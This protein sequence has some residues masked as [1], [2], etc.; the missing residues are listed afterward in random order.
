MITKITL[1]KHQ[2]EAVN[3]INNVLQDNNKCLVKM[4]CGTGKTRV[5]FYLMI[6]EY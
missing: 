6:V 4:F 5:V 2:R 3:G 1:R